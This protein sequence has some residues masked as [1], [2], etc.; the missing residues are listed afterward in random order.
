M[1]EPMSV[2]LSQSAA[3]SFPDRGQV[4]L[5]VT[6]E[7]GNA[8]RYLIHD[9]GTPVSVLHVRFALAP[10]TAGGGAVR[11]AG[12]CDAQGEQRWWIDYDADAAAVT[13]RVGDLVTLGATLNALAWHTLEVKI[14]TDAGAA[15]LWVDGRLVDSATSTLT[16][17]AA[18]KV[19]LGAAFKDTALSGELM[20]D[21]WVVATDR[22]GPVIIAPSSPYADDPSRWLVVYN[23]AVADSVAWV[24]AYRQARGVPLAN[25]CGLELP[26]EEMID[27]EQYADL[28]TAI[29]DYLHD[30]G[31]EKQ[32]LGLLTGYRVPGYVDFADDG[33]LDSVP[34]LLHRAETG[35]GLRSNENH[36]NASPV[37]PTHDGLG[38]DRLTARIDGPDLASALALIDGATDLIEKGLDDGANATLWFDPLAGSSA[39]AEWSTL[40][41]IEWVRSLDRMRLRLPLA[42]SG[43]LDKPEEPAQFEAIHDDAFLWFWDIDVGATPPPGFFAEPAGPRVVSLQLQVLE[44]MATTM[45]S[46]TPGNWIDQPLSAGYAA[47]VATSRAYTSSA[48]PHPLPFF[49]ALRRGWTLAEAWYLAV[50]FLR[51]GLYLAGDPLLRVAFPLRGWDV[52]G[53]LERLDA[54]DPDAPTHLL[55][56][57]TTELA[58]SESMRPEPG[59]SAVYLV[60]HR[61]ERGRSE[62]SVAAV[63]AVN[64]AGAARLLP[65]MPVWPDHPQWPV[66]IENGELVL[67]L[68]WER[69]VGTCRVARVELRGEVDGAD[70]I[71]LAEPTLDPRAPALTVTRPL[72]AQQ[73]RYR[74][75]LVSPEQVELTTPWSRLVRPAESPAKALNALEVHP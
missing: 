25:L 6:L 22:I 15:A 68:S 7:T 69:P 20:M 31:L 5:A 34:G 67:T 55:R 72:P 30:T 26:V 71:V 60:R 2:T 9:L 42:V 45:R 47:A 28:V 66:R 10:G 39:L 49:E 13:L 16:D 40:V 75:R 54:F 32:V 44:A 38:P 53:P 48:V 23:A 21:E 11:I 29:N 64:Q 35:P 46:A 27:D 70:E 4:G 18:Q 1:N 59:G 52:F 56:E 24:E 12:G 57:P 36:D 14:D 65:V 41:M 74:W 50:P 58:L 61:D 3:A 63:R 43:D 37:R 62:A 8:G 17:M 51:E 33:T 19:W 73:G